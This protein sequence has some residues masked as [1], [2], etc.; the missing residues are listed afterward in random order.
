MYILSFKIQMKTPDLIINGQCQDYLPLICLQRN[1]FSLGSLL[2]IQE[3][4]LHYTLNWAKHSVCL[5]WIGKLSYGIWKSCHLKKWLR[6]LTFTTGAW[7]LLSAGISNTHFSFESI[8]M[9]GVASFHW[10]KNLSAHIK[11]WDS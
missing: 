4:N 3:I 8:N 10:N 6:A 7:L 2:F 9:S 5:I 1:L 11:I